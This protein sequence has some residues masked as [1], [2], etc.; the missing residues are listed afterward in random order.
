M[1]YVENDTAQ[2]IAKIQKKLRKSE[3]QA[4]DEATDFIAKKLEENTPVFSGKKYNGKRGEYMQEHAKDNIV[5]ST[6]KD[7]YAEV[8]FNDS[9]SWR[10][11][12]TEFG[13]IKQRP[14]GFV[15]KTEK[16]V[17]QE[18]IEII[19]KVLGGIL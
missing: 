14:Q 12:F 15:Q 4:I 2:G 6:A 5:K 11:H 17:E 10:V 18:V 16:Q 3:K 13:T 8:G 1:A 19:S 9:V 7:G